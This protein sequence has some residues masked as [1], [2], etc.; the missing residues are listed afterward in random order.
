M[1]G[2]KENFFMKKAVL[3]HTQTQ[4]VRDDLDSM[5]LRIIYPDIYS[6]DNCKLCDWAHA[7]IRRILWE[8]QFIGEEKAVSP[9]EAAALW[10]AA[11][12]ISDLQDQ[13]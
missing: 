11:L 6:D 4:N 2:E 5:A 12:C 7:S 3:T 8:W 10:M 13:L 1:I 9:D